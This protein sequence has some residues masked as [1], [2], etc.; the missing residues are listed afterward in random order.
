MS[1]GKADPRAALASTRERERCR[2]ILDRAFAD[3]RLNNEQ[4][5]DRWQRLERARRLG[6]LFDLVA[7]IPEGAACIREAHAASDG[8]PEGSA[9]SAASARGAADG[10]VEKRGRNAGQPR[11]RLWL[12]AAALV[13]AAVL[14][15]AAVG[16]GMAGDGAE[17]AQQAEQAIPGG[18]YF[19][20]AGLAE[21]ADRLAVEQADAL[22]VLA[23]EDSVRVLVAAGDGTVDALDFRGGEP[24]RSPYGLRRDDQK[25]LPKLSPSTLVSVLERSEEETGGKAVL[26]AFAPGYDLAEGSER[27]LQITVK[28]TGGGK[29][30]FAAWTPDGRRLVAVH[31]ADG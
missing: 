10:G 2:T 22:E 25:V 7:D 26:L 28:T 21:V 5:R 15:A 18:T 29:S 31:S 14:G 17:D 3:G 24:E 13:A 16:I 19:S 20:E 8:G 1:G 9:G 12:T 4:M 11:K 23:S 27:E 30:F 6:E